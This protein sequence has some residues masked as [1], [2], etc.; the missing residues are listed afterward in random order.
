MHEDPHKN[1]PEKPSGVFEATDLAPSREAQWLDVVSHPASP[2]PPKM[3]PLPVVEAPPQEDTV[4]REVPSEALPLMRIL[5]IVA[6]TLIFLL[7][8]QG[9]AGDRS[10]MRPGP[11]SG[12]L[13]LTPAPSPAQD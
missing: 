7:G 2:L 10:E 8:W 12:V 13:E 6:L 5:A 1:R 9:T 11:N 3:A 4:P